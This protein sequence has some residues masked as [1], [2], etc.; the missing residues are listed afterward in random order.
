MNLAEAY[1]AA[2]CPLARGPRAKAV[3]QPV[4]VIELADAVD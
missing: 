4:Q 2:V 3:L 1:H